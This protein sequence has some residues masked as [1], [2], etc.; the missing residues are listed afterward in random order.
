MDEICDHRFFH[1]N[2]FDMFYR[3][4]SLK[5]HLDKCGNEETFKQL[6]QVKE[7]VA[8]CV[9]Q[10]DMNTIELMKRGEPVSNEVIEEWSLLDGHRTH[11]GL[12][13]RP[14]LWASHARHD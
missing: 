10:E 12:G 14:G 9:R 13:F 1:K 4:T 5:L 11:S 3:K 6:N 7:F 2:T 8:N